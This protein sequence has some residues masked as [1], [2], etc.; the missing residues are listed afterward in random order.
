MDLLKHGFMEVISCICFRL[1]LCVDIANGNI[2]EVLAS[3]KMKTLMFSDRRYQAFIK[4]ELPRL[5]HLGFL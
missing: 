5:S 3:K 4:K 1:F 2:G